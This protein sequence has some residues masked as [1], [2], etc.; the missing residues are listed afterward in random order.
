[1]IYLDNSATTKPHKEVIETFTKVAEEFFGN[2]S[3]VHALGLKAEK[4]LKTAR[5]QMA[6]LLGVKENEVVFTSGGTEG[7]NFAIKGIASKYH[8]RGKHIITTAIEHPSVLEACQQLEQEGFD[9]TYLPV[10]EQGRIEIDQLK[11][12]LREDTILVSM[13]HVNNEVGVIQP[14]REVGQLLKDYPKILFH[15]D[16][17]Q[18]AGKIPLQFH[19]A[20]IDLATISA[21]KF[22]GLKGTGAL[23]IREGLKIDPLLAGGNQER[24]YRSG[25]ENVAGIVAMSKALRLSLDN[26]EQKQKKLLKIHQFLRDELSKIDGVEVHTPNKNFANHIINFS[27]EGFKAE[28][29]VHAIAENEVY[30]STTSA[31]SS[32][33]NEP[34]KT[35]LAMGVTENQASSALRISLS[36]ENTMEEAKQAIKVITNSIQALKKTMRGSK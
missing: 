25:T 14:I 27:V 20:H 13:M 2:P 31:C 32:K 23:Y 34:C 22:H 16:Y 17:V 4:L 36:F 35:L 19:E 12:H 5:Q 33:L 28:V 15:V 30:V 21:H 11:A 3:S 7:N 26:L 9:V 29:L 1:M 18:G 6:S 10:N 24:S 8:T